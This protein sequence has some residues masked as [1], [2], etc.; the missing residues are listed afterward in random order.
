MTRT[1]LLISTYVDGCSNN[2]AYG[3]LCSIPYSSV[4][5]SWCLL[6]S[7]KMTNDCR[8]T[9]ENTRDFSN[10]WLKFYTVF[11]YN[12][13]MC[14]L[15]CLVVILN[16]YSY[17]NAGCT[18]GSYIITVAIA[19][20]PVSESIQLISYVHSATFIHTSGLGCN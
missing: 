20:S 18:L 3:S 11:R 16:A 14:K 2:Y 1:T 6:T 19:I 12:S 7:C 15:Y 17:M 4:F 9:R 10:H 13:C 8:C 5:P